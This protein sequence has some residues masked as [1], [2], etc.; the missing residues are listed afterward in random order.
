MHVKYLCIRELMILPL[1]FENKPDVYAEFIYK[2][3]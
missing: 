2:T 1:N 3:I